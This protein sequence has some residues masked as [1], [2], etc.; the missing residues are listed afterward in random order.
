VDESTYNPKNSDFQ[1]ASDLVRFIREEYGTFFGICVAGY[2]NGHPDCESIEK[3]LHYLKEKVDAGADFIIT[4]LFFEAETFIQ[5]VRDCR[6]VG[7]NCPIIPGVLPIQSYASIR[8]LMKLSKL[9]PPEK[10]V[11]E[12]EARKDDDE[13]IRRFGVSIAVEMCRKIL[14]SGVTIGFHFYTLNREV[15]VKEIVVELGM[16]NPRGNA[17]ELP[18]LCSANTKRQQEK[19][20]PIFWSG[21]PKSYLMRTKDWDEFPNGRWGDSS[22]PAFGNLA[23]YYLFRSPGADHEQKRKMWGDSLSSIQDIGNVFCRFLQGEISHLPWSEECS[24]ALETKVLEERLLRLNRQGIFTTNSQPAVNGAPSTD[25]IHGWG[26]QGGYVYQKAY[27][28]FFLSP[29]LLHR[30]VAILKKHPSF[31]FHALNREGDSI[32]NTVSATAISSV[33]GSQRK[34]EHVRC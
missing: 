29:E 4:Q 20:R 32:T 13:A 12:I 6:E 3:D 10:I 21:R 14:A 31:T 24:L 17:K 23:E 34:V 28:E 15:A 27:L 18:W 19:V 25:P 5:F 33:S 30:L 11:R 26:E 8:H 9:R 22:S 16:W 2:P 1:Y 7:I